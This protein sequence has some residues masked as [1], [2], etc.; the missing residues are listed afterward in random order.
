[1]TLEED[2]LLKY[3][4]DAFFYGSL[5]EPMSCIIGGAHASYHTKS[6]SYVHKMG[7]REGGKLAL[8][9]GAGPMGL[10]MVD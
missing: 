7:I 1:M 4:G 9:A 10:G 3:S 5:A 8:L 2:C 6:G